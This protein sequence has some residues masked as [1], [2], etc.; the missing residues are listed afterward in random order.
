MKKTITLFLFVL[1]PYIS[2][3]FSYFL[4]IEGERY[5]GNIKKETDTYYIVELENENRV[6]KLIK[7]KLV[8]IEH[9][10]DGLEVYKPEYCYEVDPN[11]ALQPFWEKAN[12]IY[13]PISSSKIAQRS[14]SGT[15]KMLLVKDTLWN[16]VDTEE[17]AHYIMRYVFDDR[18]SDKAYIEVTDR[19]KK[20]VYV[21]S[22]VSARDFVP[23][24][25]GEESAEKLYKLLKKVIRKK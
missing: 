9:E 8:L 17:Q 18:G 15:L 24:H 22:K 11:S 20:L 14:G 5:F 19:E 25:A 10:E 23:W 13:I 1:V 16:I 12:R 21:S 7:D 3:P 6:I 4:T 2:Y